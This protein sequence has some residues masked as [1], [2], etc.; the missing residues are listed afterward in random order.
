VKLSC[1]NYW[2]SAVAALLLLLA[3]PGMIMAARGVL[4]GSHA[5]KSQLPKSCRTCHQGMAMLLTGEETSC[6]P[7]H[8]DSGGRQ[9]ME[10]DGFLKLQGNTNLGDIEAELR[11]PYAHPTL[12]VRGA[13]QARETLPEEGSMPHA[14]PSASTATIRTG[15]MRVNRCAGSW[16]SV[17]AT[18][19]E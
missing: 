15:S 10:R 8:G 13:H 7:C 5:R 3:T 4:E 14:T 17:P 1:S 16:A 19:R 11:K 6:L 9:Q 12:E 18:S 2:L